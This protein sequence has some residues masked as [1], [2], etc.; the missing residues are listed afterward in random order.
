METLEST[1][2]GALVMYLVQGISW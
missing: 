2:R 1:A